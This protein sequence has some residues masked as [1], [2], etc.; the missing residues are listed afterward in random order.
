MLAPLARCSS[1]VLGHSPLSGEGRTTLD[2]VALL[3]RDEEVDGLRSGLPDWSA[4]GGIYSVVGG[5]MYLPI[6]LLV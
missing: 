5:H 3:A 2:E 4:L 6:I 1:G